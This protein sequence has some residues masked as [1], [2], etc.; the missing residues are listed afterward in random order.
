MNP[1]LQFNHYPATHPPPYRIIEEKE[2]IMIQPSRHRVYFAGLAVIALFALGL[3][4]PGLTSGRRDPLRQPI[5]AAAELTPAQW[6]E[7]LDFLGAELPKRHKNLFQKIKESEFRAQIETLKA[8]LPSLSQSEIL[9]GLMRIVAAVGDSHT[10]LGYRPKQGLPLMLYWFKDGISILNTTAEHKDILHGKITALGGKPIEDIIPILASLIPHE[11]Q[12]QVKNML[13]NLL[14]DTQILQGAGIIPSPDAASLTVLTAAGRSVTLEMMPVPFSSKPEWLSDISDESGAPLYL[15][16]RR[17]FYWFE[18]MA[19]SRTLF[20]K[21]NSCQNMKDRPFGEFV[22]ALFGAIEAGE[23]SRI[24]IDL[25]HN[26]GGNSA[27][28]APFLAELKQKP[29]LCRQGGIYVLVGRRTFSSAILN[30]LDLKKETPAVF[31]GE[32]TGG[33]P[34]HYGEVQM[35][36]L[37]KSGMAITYSVKYFQV[38]EGDPESLVP[39]IIV[40]PELADYLEKTDPVLE[41]VLER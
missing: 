35:F 1:S 24:V 12:A 37:P 16:N 10:T 33:K 40:E 28:F 30:A 2:V 4:A 31:V 18:I 6:T 39:D 17:L 26:G 19:E 5:Q 9:A 41:R 14:T 8:K 13:P 3:L 38:V 34:N 20:F 25:R 32:P 23:V 27:I 7:D 22:K 29:A 21:Y 36:L 15:R 11:N